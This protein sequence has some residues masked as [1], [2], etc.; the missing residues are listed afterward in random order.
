MANEAYEAKVPEARD[1]DPD[2]V[3]DKLS[4]AA[5]MWGRG[6]RSDALSWVRRAAESASDAELDL[7]ALELAKAASELAAT[8]EALP[9][10]SAPALAP[11]PSPPTAQ[12]PAPATAKPKTAPPPKPTQAPKPPGSRPPGSKLPPLPPL[13]PLGSSPHPGST[14]QPAAKAARI[15]SMITSASGLAVAS[16]TVDREQAPKPARPSAAPTRPMPWDEIDDEPTREVAVGPA[17]PPVDLDAT[18][19]YDRVDPH[20]TPHAAPGASSGGNGAA[21]APVLAAAPAPTSSEPDGGRITHEPRA[22]PLAVGMRVRLLARD[23]IVTV[24][25]EDETQDGVLAIVVPAN[26]DD[27]LRA[28]FARARA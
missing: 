18:A 4:I 28:I 19:T 6:D 27:D 8:L 9:P 22:L 14:T 3:A 25:P 7:R 2:E 5:A 16:G 26:A 21:S 12:A 11:A 1:D 13:R 23:G 20:A 24:V 10:P 15:P 17:E